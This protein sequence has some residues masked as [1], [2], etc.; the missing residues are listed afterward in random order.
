L[1][2]GY[3]R[4]VAFTTATSSGRSLTLTCHLQRRKK[5]HRLS[6]LELF[7]RMAELI[8]ER[9]TCVRMGVG[10][11]ITDLSFTQVLSM[12]YNG[13]ARGLNNGCV[14]PLAGQCGCVHAEANA[15]VKSNYT[16]TDQQMFCTHMPCRNCAQLIVNS[17]VTRLFYRNDYRDEA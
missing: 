17:N 2:R 11:I 12:G 10:C 3:V 5:M 16:I 15:L 9:T 4:A 1:M 8:A 14:S 13:A 7:M 6:K